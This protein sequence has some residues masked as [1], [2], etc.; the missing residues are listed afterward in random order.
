[1]THAGASIRAMRKGLGLS[2]NELARRSG[3][4]ASQLSKVERNLKTPSDRWL[5]DVKEALAA[6]MTKQ[7]GDAA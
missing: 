5:R 2:L 6:E 3:V 4:N 1:M 7:R